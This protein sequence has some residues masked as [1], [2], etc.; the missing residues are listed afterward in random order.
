MYVLY[1]YNAIVTIHNLV[2]LLKFCR[3]IFRYQQYIYNGCTHTKFSRDKYKG[4]LED[5][6]D[7]Y[8][9]LLRSET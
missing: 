4:K 3:Q 6:L 1:G 8:A 5:K 7:N 2:K 9:T